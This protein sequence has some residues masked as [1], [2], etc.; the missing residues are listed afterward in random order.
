M[1]HLCPEPIDPAALRQR[2]A[3]PVAGALAIFEGWVRNHNEGQPV[4]SLEYEAAPALCDAEAE[5][6]LAEARERFEILDAIVVHRVGHLQIGDMAVWVGVTSRHRAAAF[7][8]CRY[9]V[10]ELKARLPIWKKE[11]YAAGSAKWIG[12]DVPPV[13]RP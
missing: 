7:D 3:N 9:L 13:Q 2:L 1:F 12:E 6:L 11:H 5:R 4:A 8:A 10:E